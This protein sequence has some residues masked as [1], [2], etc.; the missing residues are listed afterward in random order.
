MNVSD[1]ILKGYQAAAQELNTVNTGV[2]GSGT[3]VLEDDVPIQ[4]SYVPDECDDGIFGTDW[5]ARDSI[6][7]YDDEDA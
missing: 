6:S 7:A 5:I 1:W 3:E 2:N 4:C